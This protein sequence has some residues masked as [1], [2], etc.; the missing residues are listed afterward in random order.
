[1]P[2]GFSLRGTFRLRYLLVVAAVLGSL[3]VADLALAIPEEP[4]PHPTDTALKCPQ[5]V[6]LGEEA[7][8]TVTVTDITPPEIRI[9]P[10]GGVALSSNKAGTFTA[11]CLLV[12]V[13]K[14]QSR[15]TIA[16]KPAVVGTHLII[17][18]Y[19]GRPGDETT[20]GLEPSEG[21]AQ[22]AVFT[23]NPTTTTVA[24]LPASV[25]A[26][27]ASTCTATVQDIGAEPTP[28]NGT[29]EFLSD[30][31]GSFSG[32][33]CTLAAAG[34]SK[35]GCSAPTPRARSA[36]AATRSP[37]STA[38]PTTTRVRARPSSPSPPGRLRRR[39]TVAPRP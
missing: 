29:I 10:R 3:V 4:L 2:P 11:S 23:S 34:Q 22:V 15:C 26:N 30:G 18:A 36:T 32:A 33:S 12:T 35:A 25:K 1:M 31:G 14:G 17:A 38:R 13:V 16:Y 19:E 21:L 7:K 9:T 28:P 24:C 37:R 8:C 27:E 6:A 39:L 20:S 5:A